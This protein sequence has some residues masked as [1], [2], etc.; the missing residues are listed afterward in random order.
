MP[1]LKGL[2]LVE[3]LN[4]MNRNWIILVVTGHD[5]FEYARRALALRVFDFVLKPVPENH[6]R[7][8]LLRA[9]QEWGRR[10]EERRYLDWSREKL[11]ALGELPSERSGTGLAATARHLLEA[12]YQD[13]DL[14]LEDVAAELRVS[15]NHLSRLIKEA[16][17]RPFVQFLCHLRMEKAKGLL[18]DPRLRISEV[19]QRVGYRDQ[20]YFCRHFKTMAGTTPSGW[21]SREAA[22]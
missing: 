20:N 17:G 12:R 19:A 10:K 16:T 5:E 4:A 18:D 1:R 6:F 3:R 2:E 14:S 13:A 7:E 22:P 8:L 21:R 15:P 9:V 11:M